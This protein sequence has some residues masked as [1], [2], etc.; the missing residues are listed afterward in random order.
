MKSKRLVI[1]KNSPIVAGMRVQ[2]LFGLRIYL[3]TRFNLISIVY[4]LCAKDGFYFFIFSTFIT[5]IVV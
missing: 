3:I 5:F 4:Q 1:R 2:E